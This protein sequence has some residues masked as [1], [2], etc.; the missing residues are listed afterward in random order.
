MMQHLYV[1]KQ[2][3]F[4]YT[5]PQQPPPPANSAWWPMKQTQHLYLW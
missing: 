2:E 5:A 1:I 4:I 3:Y